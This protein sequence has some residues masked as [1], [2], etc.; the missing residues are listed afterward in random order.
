MYTTKMHPDLY[1]DLCGFLAKSNTA[2][3]LHLEEGHEE[4]QKQ[5][6]PLKRTHSETLLKCE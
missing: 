1:R 4:E 2:F 5:N 3:Q 6:Q